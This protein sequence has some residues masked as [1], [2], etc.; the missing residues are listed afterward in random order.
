[1]PEQLVVNGNYSK[2]S[3]IMVTLQMSGGRH[4]ERSQAYSN[5]Q[6]LWPYIYYHKSFFQSQLAHFL[7][8]CPCGHGCWSEIQRM[9]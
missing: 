6:N 9:S 7:F 5:S 4:S 8:G 3:E 1:M 2:R